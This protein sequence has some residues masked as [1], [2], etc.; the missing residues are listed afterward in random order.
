MIWL[1]V[2]CKS[3]DDNLKTPVL[4]VFMAN[5]FQLLILERET[6]YKARE[7]EKYTGR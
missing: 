3:Y 5:Y 1:C 4:N 7:L 6:E 2:T